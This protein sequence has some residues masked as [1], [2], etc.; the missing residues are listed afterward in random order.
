MHKHIHGLAQIHRLAMKKCNHKKTSTAGCGKSLH[1]WFPANCIKGIKLC[2]LREHHFR[3]VTFLP[4]LHN[5]Y[6]TYNETE[7]PG[8]EEFS[9]YHLYAPNIVCQSWLV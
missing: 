3:C 6:C 8:K 4:I 9:T 1:I 2:S 7:H 5:M